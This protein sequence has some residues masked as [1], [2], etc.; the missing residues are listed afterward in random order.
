MTDGCEKGKEGRR[1]GGRSSEQMEEEGG[2][3]GGEKGWE[4]RNGGRRRGGVMEGEI[5]RR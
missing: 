1:E 5:N 3:G 4:G 2:I